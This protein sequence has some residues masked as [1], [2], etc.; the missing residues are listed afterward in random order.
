MKAEV[1]HFSPEDGGS[2]LL[3]NVGLYQ[4]IHTR[5]NPKE[6]GQNTE[7]RTQ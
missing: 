2:T 3:R 1:D 7:E 5:F 6:H 4:T